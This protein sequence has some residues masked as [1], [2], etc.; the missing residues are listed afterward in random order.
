MNEKPWQGRFEQPTNRQVEEYT[1]SIHFDSRLFRYDIEGSIAHCRMLGE[2]GIITH[3]EAALIIGGLGEVLREMERGDLSLDP[4]EEDIHMAVE[5]R[6]IQKIGEVGGKLHTARSRN[7]QICLDMRLYIRD[8]I[9]HCRA[10]LLA[11]RKGFVETASCCMGM[12]MPGF[13]HLQ[14]AQPVLLSHHLMAYD[15]MFR[16]DDER[17]ADCFRRADVLPLGSAALAGTTFPIDMEYTARALGFS[18]VTRNSIDAVSDRDYLIEFNSA[19]AILV[20]HVS[21]LAEELILWSTS[22]F[23]FIEISDAFCTGSSIMPQKKNPDVPE[24]MRGKSARVFGNLMALLSLT[25]A[26]PLAYNRDLQEDKEPVF[27]TADTVLS[28]LRLLSRLLPE[29]RFKEERM[30]RM[31]VEGFT[32]AT[33]LADYLVGKGLPFRKAHHVV[34]QIVQHCIHHGKGLED[35]GLD[36]LRSFSK[37]FESDVSAFLNI[38]AAVN[39]RSSPGGTA[40][41]RVEEAIARARDEIRSLERELPAR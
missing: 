2:C 20:M 7:D 19:A 14:H 26:L 21:R 8:V 32:L 4:S 28:T 41:S 13:T 40:S 35:C 27:D 22:E 17:M 15:E 24:L 12:V 34:G 36:D 38:N 16:R 10:L 23:A 11:V 31:A 37:L 29:I 5:R 3:E 25:K 6:L 39:R 30:R 33:E 18:Q 1:A 9:R